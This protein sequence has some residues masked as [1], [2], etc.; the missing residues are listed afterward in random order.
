[1]LLTCQVRSI[2]IFTTSS[3][4]FINVNMIL[5]CQVRTDLQ[6]RLKKKTKTRLLKAKLAVQVLLWV[7]C[8]VVY[9]F[10]V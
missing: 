6:H 4:F 9:N 3:M 7:G 5:T 2:L 10:Y 1:M 8:T